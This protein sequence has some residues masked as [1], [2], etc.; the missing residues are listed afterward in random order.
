MAYPSVVYWAATRHPWSCVWFV[1]P[2]LL[3]YEVGLHLQGPTPAEALRNGADVWLR[4]A[5]AGLGLSPLYAPP[6]LLVVILLTWSMLYRENRPGDHLGVWIG[7]IVESVVFAV[8]LYG[9]SRGILPLLQTLGKVFETRP[10]V[11]AWNGVLGAATTPSQPEPAVTH[12]VRYL[13]AGIYEETLFRLVLFSGLL[14]AFNLIELPRW[15]G[16]ALA[17]VV[18]ALLFAGAHNI[19]PQ[20]EPFHVCV[21]LFRTLAGLYFAWLY[22]IRGFGIAVGTHAGYDVLVGILMRGTS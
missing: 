11:L 8:A 2:L 3:V 6:V 15:W 21:F 16:L 9:L 18:S 4:S 22:C 7:M 13:G 1:L 19:G 10:A 17:G 5:L 12:L 20:G 14:A